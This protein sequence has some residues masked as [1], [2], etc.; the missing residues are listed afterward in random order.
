MVPHAVSADFR[1]IRSR[2]DQGLATSRRRCRTGDRTHPVGASLASILVSRAKVHGHSSPK[3]T[4]WVQ[5]GTPTRFESSGRPP[6]LF[7]R[8]LFLFTL[9]ANLAEI[10]KGA[11]S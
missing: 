3:P 4:R 8:V 6:F 2:A 10:T 11:K 5:R 1:C 7:V 9:P